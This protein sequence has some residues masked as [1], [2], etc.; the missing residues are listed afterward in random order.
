M[1]DLII[2][3]IVVS[4]SGALAPGPLTA[5]TATAGLKKGWKAGIETSIGHTIVELPLV[6]LLSVGFITLLK[7]PKANFWLGLL[8][9]VF[10]LYFGIITV[11][12]SFSKREAKYESRTPAPII[13]GIVLTALNPYFLAWWIGIG[14]SLIPLAIEKAGWFGIG[15]LYIFHVWLDYAWL[16]FIAA[17]SSLGRLKTT[18]YRIILCALGGMVLYFGIT[19]MKKALLHF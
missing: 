9:S 19:M 17:I 5:A 11:R 16:A 14:S 2:K 7:N 1:F 10:L 15:I 18:V 6:I 13:T 4:A 8:G 12:E 3:I